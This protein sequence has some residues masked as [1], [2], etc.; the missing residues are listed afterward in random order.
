MSR[1]IEGTA[2][3]RSLRLKRSSSPC[4]QAI[5]PAPSQ[6][7]EGPCFGLFARRQQAAP[8]GPFSAYSKVP[9]EL[10]AACWPEEHGIHLT[11]FGATSDVRFH[12][13]HN[14]LKASRDPL[15]ESKPQ[16]DSK[17]AVRRVVHERSVEFAGLTAFA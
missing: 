13:R 15:Q 7:R 16:S 14:V 10:R 6:P 11:F 8:R 1:K 17:E 5:I 12:E 3:V 9:K 2:S 4:R